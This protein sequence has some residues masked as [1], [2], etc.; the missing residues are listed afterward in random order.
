MTENQ[1]IVPV[2]LSDSSVGG[3]KEPSNISD[4]SP[5]CQLKINGAEILFY[6]GVDKHIL[7]VVLAEVTKKAR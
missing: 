3:K 5:S 6:N 4:S 7:H 1:V 2:K